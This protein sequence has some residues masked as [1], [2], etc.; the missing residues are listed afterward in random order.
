MA[1]QARHGTATEHD[2]RIAQG[3]RQPRSGGSPAGGTTPSQRVMQV[4]VLGSGDAFGAGGR[5]HSAYVTEAPGATFLLDCGPSILQAAKQ[6]GFDVGRLDAVLLSHL[7]GDHFGGVPFLFMEYLYEAPRT[8]PLVICG[9]EDTER[10]VKALFSA[11]YERTAEDPMPFPVEYRELRAGDTLRLGEA[12]VTAI[13][14]HHVPELTS[15]GYLVEVRGRRVLYSGDTAWTDEL[16]AY[17]RGVDLFICE[18]STYETRL[19]IH[20]SYPEIADRAQE[21]GCRRVLL[22]HLGSE[23]LRRLSEITL[24]CARDGMTVSL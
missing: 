13:P 23:P 1:I 5:F 21:L 6:I 4:T 8:R 12:Q 14:V 24:E 3:V 2:A 7:H 17:A 15:F 19:D 11:L 9:P 22:S 20:V 16:A 18:C 10:R